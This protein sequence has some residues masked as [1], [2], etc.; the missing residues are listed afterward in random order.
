MYNTVSIPDVVQQSLITLWTSVAGF[1]PRLVAALVVFLVGWL[2]A[3]VLAKLVWHL[4]KAIQLDRALESVG[5][6]TVWEKSGH[7]LDSSFLFYELV[8]WFF[9][10]VFLM[11]AADILGLERVTAFLYSVVYYFPN[12]IIAAVVLIIGV[13]VARFAERLVRGSVRI[14]EFGS[15]NTLAIITRWAIIVFTALAAL[16]QLGFEITGDIARDVIRGFIAALALA[17]GLAFGLGGRDHADD[18]LA[19]FRKHIQE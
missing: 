5:F 6:K 7:K 16:S 1:L 14:A 11:A 13:L 9:L 18:Y 8:K 19:K 10:V 4:V 2:I 17:F 15:A 12:V 3:V